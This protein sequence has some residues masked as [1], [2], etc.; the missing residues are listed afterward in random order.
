MSR[1]VHFTNGY[2]RRVQIAIAFKQDSCSEYGRPWGTRGWWLLD[3]GQ[4][5][6][7]LDTDNRYCYFYAEA[8][9]GSRVWTDS[10]GPL[11]P[12]VPQAFDSCIDIGSTAARDV[13]MAKLD[14]DINNRW[15]LT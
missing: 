11:V 13:A 1:D 8:T 14:L 15:R 10:L 3:P 6:Y 9:D 7:V 12:V 2:S 4:Q 5:A